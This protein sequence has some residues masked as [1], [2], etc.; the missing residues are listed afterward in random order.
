[1]YRIGIQSCGYE[2]TEENFAKLQASKIDAIEISM[3]TEKFDKINYKEVKYLADK[4]GIELW[5]YHLPFYPFSKLNIASLNEDVR[6][7]TIEYYKSLITKSTEIG[8]NKFI[9]HPSGEPNADNQREEI[10]KCSME[11]L[12]TL[13]EFA[14]KQNAVIAVEDLPRTCI[15][16]TSDEILR[17]LTANDKLRI[18]FDTNHLLKD[19]NLDFIKKCGDKII[20]IHVSD[21]DF[22]DEKHWLPGEGKINWKEFIDNF[23]K[24]NY[25]GVWMY[26]LSLRNES[27]ISRNR[28]LTFDDFYINANNIFNGEDPLKSIPNLTRK[29]LV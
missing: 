26:E 15:G 3:A 22:I 27:T 7:N 2:L 10:I 23:N 19:S 17:L 12:D 9:V 25:K 28:D 1:M 11:S 5:S 6:K 29:Y 21:Y 18:C 4:Y 13:A 20:T 16:N 14:N 24:I 8:I